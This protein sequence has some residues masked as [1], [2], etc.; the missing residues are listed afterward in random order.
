MMGAVP[1]PTAPHGRTGRPPRTSRAQILAAARLLI[2]QDG[3]EKL[4]VRRLASELGVGATTL[5]HH[6]RDREDL[7]V[8]LLNDFADQIPRPE[9]SGSPRDR[10]VAAGVALHDALA[11]WPWAAEALT[12]DGFLGRL[13][14]SALSI[15]ETIVSSAIDH[16]CPAERAV[17]VFR[18]IWYYTVGEILV[19]ANTDRRRTSKEAPAP[20]DVFFSGVDMS[21]LPTLRSIGDKWPTL[22]ARNIFPQGLR[23]FVDGLLAANP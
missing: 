7:L 12:A 21:Q 23:A 18:N 15:V 14:E 20:G 1:Q 2:D 19:R 4:T 9:P 17:D 16:G 6:V 10:I 11:A 5:Y 13:N 22:A 8:Q 3:W